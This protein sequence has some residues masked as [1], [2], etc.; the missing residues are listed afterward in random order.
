MNPLRD[1]AAITFTAAIFG[2]TYGLS[3]P[4]IA[5]QMDAAGWSEFMIGANAAMHALGVLLVAPF[6]PTLVSRFGTARSAL[7]ALAGGGLT[8][9]LFPFAPALWLWFPLRLALG[10]VSETLFV[11]TETWINQISSEATRARSIAFYVAS[12]SLG[13]ALGPAI[14]AII[15]S[16]G[17]LP[18][19]AGAAL[20]LV[21]LAVFVGMAPRRIVLDYHPMMSPLRALRL[22]PVAI[23]ATMLNAALET[24]GLTLLP[25]YA[26]DAGWSQT[27]ATLLITILMVGAI[28]LQLPIGW[29]GDRMDRRRLALGLAAF[30]AAGA[31]VWPFALADPWIAYP[32]LFV[33]GGAF[34]G[35]YTIMVTVIGS[36]FQ[37]AEQVSLYAILSVV[38]G[39]GALLG[40][41]MGGTAM[42]LTAHGLPLFAAVSCAALALFMLASRSKA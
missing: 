4:L 22:A 6:L 41:L 1:Q 31:A 28:V 34:A 26:M 35:I 42:H 16:E 18:F 3:A 27:H 15:G 39:F 7:A 24:A 32:L 17:P 5:L 21:A 19:L 20:S 38:W 23:F 37:G 14:I 9:F 40:P 12:L 8:L 25:L 2:L 29:L 36:R 11:T 10:I 33:W 30:S 13:F